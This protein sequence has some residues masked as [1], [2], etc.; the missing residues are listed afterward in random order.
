M[1]APKRRAPIH[2]RRNDVIPVLKKIV[3]TPTGRFLY[4]A[5]V[6]PNLQCLFDVRKNLSVFTL[7]DRFPISFR[8]NRT[9][10]TLGSTALGINHLLAQQVLSP[11]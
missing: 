9:G 10:H 4:N 8:N 7:F 5:V 6:L 3:L 2:P 1:S 11:P